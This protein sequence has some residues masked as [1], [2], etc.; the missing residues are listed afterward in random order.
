MP[1]EN[2]TNYLSNNS[3][4]IIKILELTDFH[5]ISFYSGKNEIRCA[6]YEGGNP[7]S[8]SINC[9]T[10]QAYVF[11]KGMG[12]SLFYIISIHNGWTLNKTIQFILQELKIA[13]INDIKVPYIFNGVHKRIYHKKSQNDNILSKNTLDNYIYHPNLRFLKDNISFETQYKF[14]ICYDNISNRIIV[15]WFDIKGNLVGITGRYNFEELGTNPKWKTL[16]NFSKGNYLYGIYENQIDIKNSEYVIIGESEKFVMQ[17]DSYGYHNGLALGN[18]NITDKQARIIKS[19]PV[20]KIIIALDEGISA[21]HILKQCEKLKGGI[22]NNNKEIWCI[23]DSNN[24]IMPKGSK[25][26]PS[27]FGKENFEKLLKNFCFKKE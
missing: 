11:S 25:A 17:L 4:E 26:S 16:K 22:F 1:I 10:L 6:Y 8:V 20:K 24:E 21:E 3:D 15:P 5:D 27:D 18:C 9:E 14:N 19:L 23:Y 13:D 2:L 12:G 7:T